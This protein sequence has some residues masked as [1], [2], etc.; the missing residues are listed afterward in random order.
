MN[1]HERQHFDALLH[2]AVERLTER[3]VQRS[4]G[5]TGALGQLRDDPDGEGVWLGDFLDAF[6][7]EALLDNPAGAAFVLQALE[8]QTVRL[9]AGEARIG[10]H[11]QALAKQAFRALLVRKLDESL[12]QQ[13]AYGA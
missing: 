12:S 11:L 4:Q 10:D 7:A 2:L 13:L 1:L 5:A 8:R 9:G 3:A 6:F